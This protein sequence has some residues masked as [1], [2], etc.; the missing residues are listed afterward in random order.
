M[1]NNPRIPQGTLNKIRAHLIVSNNNSLNLTAPY[2]GKGMISISFGGNAVD[3]IDTAS[4]RVASPNPYMDVSVTLDILKT[5]G[6]FQIWRN[7]MEL[8]SV[9]GQIRTVGD[10][11]A[12]SDY[13]FSNCSIVSVSDLPYDGTTPEC[14][15]TLSGT[16]YINS[17][18]WGE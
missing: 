8:N 6:A 5:N 10:T 3:Y 17:S 9:I 11:S 2:L 16:Y 12:I 14:R 15:I 13:T 1:A 4:G 18:L 7:Q